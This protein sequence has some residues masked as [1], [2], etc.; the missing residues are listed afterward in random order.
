MPYYATY[1]SWLPANSNEQSHLIFGLSSSDIRTATIQSLIS[2]RES[3]VNNFLEPRYSTPVTS[4][5]FITNIVEDLVTYDI[6]KLLIYRD[7][8]LDPAISDQYNIALN[9]LTRLQEGKQGLVN[10]SG[11]TIVVKNSTSRFYTTGRNYTHTFNVD[12]ELNWAVSPGRL[13]AIE[14]DRTADV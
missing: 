14:D 10:D 2:R 3:F 8:T 13:D 7:G 9:T 4:C 1:T 11:T 12:N 6:W 5:S